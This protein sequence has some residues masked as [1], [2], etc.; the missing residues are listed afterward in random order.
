MRKAGG[1]TYRR[2]MTP[3]RPPAVV[4]PP[5]RAPLPPRPD[6]AL[7]GAFLVLTTLEAL[8]GGG[9]RPLPVHLV[10][11]GVAMTALAWR[12]R[13]PVLVALVVLAANFYVNPDG[14]FSTLLALVLVSYSIGAYADPPR[15]YLGLAV[16]GTSFATAM[17][18]EGLVP[19]DLGAVL[20]FVVGPWTVGRVLRQRSESAAAAVSRADLLVREREAQTHRAVAEE[21][22]RIARELHDIVSHSISVVTIQ[23]QA[24]RR[25]LRPDQERE[26]ADL[27][28][29][30]ATAR[31]ALAEMRRLFG[32]L[33]ADGE[34]ASL[35]PQP[36]LAEL[37][38]LVAGADSPDLAVRLAVHG[39]PYPLT[40]GID[41]AAY[42]IAQEGLTNALRH[43]GASRVDIEVRY[44]PKHLEVAITDDGRG[45][46]DSGADAG[47]GN[48]LVGIRERVA[49]YAGTVTLGPANGRGTRLVARLPV[50]APP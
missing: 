9:P 34:T 36:G 6:A 27:A 1:S 29:V 37:G 47:G 38:R 19:S 49:L 28:A 4:R 18:I 3:V 17:V 13:F 48:G 44:E 33:R 14:Q 40:P 25:R 2:D 11:T 30:E 22:T 15:D 31:Q 20:V 35:A 42:R 43:S 24:V 8:Y 5:T 21:R 7:A 45:L 39:E 23:T 32:V 12:R 50:G 10:V 41:L 46:P 16:M 26:A